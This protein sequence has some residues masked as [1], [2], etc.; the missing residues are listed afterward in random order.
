M[1]TQTT[2][3]D[4]TTPALLF[5]AI[6]LLLLAYTNRFLALAS[7]IRKLHANHLVAPQSN[8]LEQISNLRRRVVLIRNMQALGV[9]SLLGCTVCMGLLFIG[10]N[11]AG[12]IAFAV[13]LLLMAASLA[14]SIV[15][16]RLSVGALDVLLSD[17]DA[18]VDKSTE[19]GAIVNPERPGTFGRGL[20]SYFRFSVSSIFWSCLLVAILMLWTRERTIHVNELAKLNSRGFTG[21]SAEQIVGPPDTPYFGDVTTA[22]ASKSPDGSQEWIVAEF[23]RSVLVSA[24]EVVE[25][26]N[27]GAVSEILTVSMAGIET[28]IWKGTDPLAGQGLRGGTA[29][30]PISQ[31][32]STR[33]IKIAVDSKTVPGWNEIDAVSLVDAQGKKT[34]AS[35]AWTSSS[36]GNHMPIPKWF[37]P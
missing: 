32:I 33:R 15:E 11:S 4:L 36:F 35:Q 28:S 29:R 24:I 31:P 30:F 26:Y 21:W 18:A 8:Y 34:W 2:E 14:L 17:M 3:L 23:P 5:P 22:W 19:P 1:T 6:S 25:T 7:L 10:W 20:F 9:S 16:I 27:P 37:W 13:A 12:T